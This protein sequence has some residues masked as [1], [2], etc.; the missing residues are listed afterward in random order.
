VI[1]YAVSFLLAIPSPVIWLFSSDGWAAFVGLAGTRPWP[2]VALVLA[3]GQTVCFG[4]LYLGGDR[5]VRRFPRVQRRIERFDAGRFHGL[6]YLW[7]ALGA[8]VGLPP[9]LAMSVLGRTL[10]LSFATLV[11]FSLA[12]RFLRFAVLAAVPAY[13]AGHLPLDWIPDWLRALA[14]G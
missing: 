8:V 5:L 14:T 2:L 1:F 9:M 13:F 6:V 12:G 10:N 4:A 3:A 7:L 11:A